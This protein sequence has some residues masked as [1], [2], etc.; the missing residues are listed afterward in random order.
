M[1]RRFRTSVQWGQSDG[2][3]SLRGDMNR[4]DSDSTSRAC[5]SING[6]GPVMKMVYDRVS[7][8]E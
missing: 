3:G 4:A 5:M 1:M 2:R 8:Q 7:L 6:H